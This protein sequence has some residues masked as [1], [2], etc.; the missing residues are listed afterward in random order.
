VK[1]PVALERAI[2]H[3][4]GFFREVLQFAPPS[5]DVVKEARRGVKV[6]NPTNKVMTAKQKRE[7]GLNE[8]LA[9]YDAAINNF[10][11]GKQ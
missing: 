4:E 10:L 9:A 6:A 1:D 7:M 8:H 3:A 2:S 5:G 11:M